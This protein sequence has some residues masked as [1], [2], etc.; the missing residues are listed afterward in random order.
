MSTEE[1]AQAAPDNPKVLIIVAVSLATIAMVVG[2]VIGVTQFYEQSL[3]EEVDSVELKP[4]DP[5]LTQL[6][7]K[8]K[9]ELTSYQWID[10]KAKTVRI[11]LDRAID[12]TLA[13]WKNRPTGTVPGT[14]G[15]TQ[16]LP[17]AAAAPALGAAPA[18]PAPG[19]PAAPAPTPAAPPP[20]TAT[21]PKTP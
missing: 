6:R 8:E 14:A 12:L 13:D 1:H 2:I 3:H 7:A 19:T 18:A 4:V 21:P 15:A 10:Q 20:A 17:G 11:P 9:P 16:P 5:R